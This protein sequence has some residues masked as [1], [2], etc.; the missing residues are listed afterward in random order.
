MQ[1]KKVKKTKKAGRN[2]KKFWKLGAEEFN[3]QFLDVSKDG[4]LLATEGHH[5]YNLYDIA[6]KYG[7]MGI[8][9][10]YPIKVI[11]TTNIPVLK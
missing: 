10:K 8:F 3:T 11:E 2:W 7:C 6:K 1:K 4:E 9:F 5:V